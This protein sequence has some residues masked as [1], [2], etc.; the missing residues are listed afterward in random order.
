[1]TGR[2]LSSFGLAPA[3]ARTPLAVAPRSGRRRLC[4]FS[5]E[6]NRSAAGLEYFHQPLCETLSLRIL[7]NPGDVIEIIQCRKDVGPLPWCQRHTHT[8]IGS[9]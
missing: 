3:L 6:P 1:V 7:S 2:L 4:G 5:L 8:C 9:F